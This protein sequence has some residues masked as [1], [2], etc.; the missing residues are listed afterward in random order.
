MI[1]KEHL[2]ADRLE[3]LKDGL[4]SETETISAL[5]HIGECEQ[6]ADAFAQS[7][8]GRQLLELPAG[9]KKAVFSAL[10]REGRSAGKGELYRYGFRVSIAACI[11]LLLLF[12]GTVN[13]G[14]NFGR[15]IHTDLPEVGLITE[16]LRGFSDRLIQFEVNEYLKEEL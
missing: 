5:G 7:Y 15:S 2:T 14:I 3:A 9:F 8:R 6:C 10:K 13:Y 16:N 11:T 1:N 4:L 12:T